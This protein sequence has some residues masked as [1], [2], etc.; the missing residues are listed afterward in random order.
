MRTILVSWIAHNHDFIR[1]S[2]K[3]PQ[4]NSNG[5]HAD[6]YS[7]LYDYDEHLLLSAPYENI[8]SRELS[9]LLEYLRTQYSQRV[10]TP[11]HVGLDDIISVE[12]IKIKLFPILNKYRDDQLD[13]YISPGTPAMQTAWY[14][15]AAEFENVKLFQVRPPWDKE[16][17]REKEYVK[18]FH[19]GLVN[20]TILK[21]ES[22]RK[23][24][25]INASF[26]CASNK[27][28]FERAEKAALDNRSTVLILGETGTGKGVLAKYIHQESLRNRHPFVPIN[29]GAMG[30]ELLESR[31]FGYMKGAHNQA[32]KDTPGAFE[33]THKGT[34]FLDEIGDISKKMQQTL[35]KVLDDSEVYRI[36]SSK[37]IKVDVR[38][39]AATNKDLL[40]QVRQGSFRADLYYRLTVTE[41]E[42]IPYRVFSKE[43][44]KA[45]FDY[46]IKK[47]A[48]EYQRTFPEMSKDVKKYLD[49]YWFPGN[50]REV[51][52]ILES[53]CASGEET[54][55][56]DLLPNRIKNPSESGFS[57]LLDDI[58]DI[59]IEKV[60]RMFGGS[61]IKAAEALGK[62]PNTIDKRIKKYGWEL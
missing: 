31:L 7:R 11:I 50:F 4:I 55:D 61:K 16:S 57:L 14:L 62:A 36:G 15:L 49:A 39:I 43:E 60:W 58:I 45:L 18:V 56:A 17:K 38:I 5:T 34:L 27:A 41:M 2:G 26:I 33:D 23:K 37:P 51:Q 28:L 3:L 47:L 48:S 25:S 29:C 9:L 21:E 53:F 59:H 6:F 24:K 44:K 19:S 42:T 32:Y 12:E 1:E 8:P 13:I 40:A 46:L 10:I 22:K 20:G 30:D 35:L 52:H 54:I